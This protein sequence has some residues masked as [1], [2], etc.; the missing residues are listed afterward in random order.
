MQT[1]SQ[2]EANNLG[3][4][5]EEEKKQRP[6]QER[7]DVPNSV[8]TET[9]SVVSANTNRQVSLKRKAHVQLVHEHCTKKSLKH[10]AKQIGN[11][12]EAGPLDPEQG[13][14]AAGVGPIAEPIADY[15]NAV[16]GG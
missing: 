15:H 12:F 2:H 9:T 1:E 3:P 16:A 8:V 13:K 4:Q 5:C 7:R 10:E 11:V 6:K 14:A